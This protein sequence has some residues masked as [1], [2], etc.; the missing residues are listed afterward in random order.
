MSQTD[1]IV[2]LN[3]LGSKTANLPGDH[4]ILLVGAKTSAGSAVDG[5]LVKDLLTET[6]FNNTFGITSQLAKAGRALIKIL[7]L[8][9]K[10]PTI[11][12]IGK[13]DNGSG[14]D[15]TA[16]VVFAGTATAAGTVSIF[17]D[18]T[19]DGKYD[20]AIAIGD[21]ATVVGDALEA[22]IT[23]N[24]K[25][26]V[27]AAN[28]T[29]TVT[30][31]AVNAGTQGNTIG[32]KREGAVGGITTTI[33]AK[34]AG[35]ATDPVLTA[36]FDPIT[37]IR[38][39][40][41]VY[42]AEWGVSTLT[43]FLDPRFNVDNQILDGVGIVCAFDTF[44]NQNTILDALNEQT[45]VYMPRKL[46]DDTDYRGNDIFESPITIAAEQAAYRGLRLTVDANISSFSQNSITRGGFYMGAIP[47]HNTPFANLPVIGSGR[48]FIEVEINELISSGGTLLVNNPANLTILSRS[49]RTT[50]K[51]DDQG[52]P[53]NSFK[54]LNFIDTLTLVREFMFNN[55]K[56]D[57]AVQ[58][59]L[60]DSEQVISP[61]TLNA[62]EIVGIFVGYYNTLSGIGGDKR[63]TLLK[64]GGAEQSAFKEAIEE[65]LTIDLTVGKIEAQ[66]IAEIL[67]QLRE[68]NIDIIQTFN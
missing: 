52:Q 16:T 62:E 46:V 17:V 7:N 18:N 25:S 66:L 1:P 8:S 64:A 36:L 48:G 49:T 5:A 45:L 54:F 67:S 32:I 26:V 56:F 12:A 47:Y 6:D 13:D 50:Y 28:V 31:T 20:I 24:T 33:A 15:A 42:P 61:V 60:T 43:D 38:Y 58:H 11:A 2:T 30:L 4:K 29:G 21:T 51:T 9:S 23:A 35:G 37:D 53:D 39:Q 59:S 22:A 68:A 41:I 19:D 10:R 57:D 40:T 34:L 65:S 55:F 27:T 3:I 14:V 44:A 63:F